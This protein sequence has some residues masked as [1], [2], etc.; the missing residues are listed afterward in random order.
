MATKDLKMR[1]DISFEMGFL[2]DVPVL[3]RILELMYTMLLIAV[4]SAIIGLI[5]AV[6]VMWLWN[7]VFGALYTINVWQAWALN[8]LAGI[9]FGK[10]GNGKK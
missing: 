4:I 8:V 1:L 9:L 3:G 6:P 7:Y 5:L 10:A 2:K